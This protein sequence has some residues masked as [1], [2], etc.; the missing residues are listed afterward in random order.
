M[1]FKKKRFVQRSFWLRSSPWTLI[2]VPQRFML[3]AAQHCECLE[4]IEQH[5]IL[6]VLKA[7]MWAIAYYDQVFIARKPLRRNYF[8]NALLYIIGV[9]QGASFAILQFR[10]F[11]KW[12]PEQSEDVHIK[13]DLSELNFQIWHK[14]I[15]HQ[16]NRLMVV[17]KIP[18]TIKK[19]YSFSDWSWIQ[20]L[21]K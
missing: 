18:A 6:L 1:A 9:F 4:K 7:L 19:Y 15:P 11:S 8:F 20:I 13:A 2:S 17:R 10:M 16:R 5:P 3:Q 12:Y 21:P 14:M